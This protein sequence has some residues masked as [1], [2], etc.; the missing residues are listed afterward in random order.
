MEG[1][2][3]EHRSVTSSELSMVGKKKRCKVINLFSLLAIR[4][5]RHVQFCDLVQWGVTDGLV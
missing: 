1:W 2:G 5:L 4:P 3:W